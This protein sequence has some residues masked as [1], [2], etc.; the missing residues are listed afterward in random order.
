MI[1]TNSNHIYLYR[2]L[3]LK[4]DIVMP[5]SMVHSNQEVTISDVVANFE[6]KQKLMNMGFTKGC[7]LYVLQGMSKGSIVVKVRDSKVV[8]N[9]STA[10]KIQC[11]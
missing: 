5:L 3:F 6:L 9:A 2:L 11:S 8:L 7:K 10:H 4:G 1:I